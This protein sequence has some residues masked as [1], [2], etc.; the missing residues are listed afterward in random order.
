M[1]VEMPAYGVGL[2]VEGDTLMLRFPDRQ[3]V[4]I[5]VSE[6]GRIINVLRVRWE[7]AQRGA[8]MGIGTTAAPVAHDWELVQEH[9]S[10]EEVEAKAAKKAADRIAAERKALMRRVAK[11]EAAKQADEL[12]A[13]AG[14]A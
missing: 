7:Y 8:R 14:L 2:W 6:F 10:R 3:L 12:L 11:R 1:D 9:L 13:L 5:P 4:P